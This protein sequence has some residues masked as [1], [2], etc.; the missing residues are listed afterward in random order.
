MMFK[1]MKSIIVFS[2]MVLMSFVFYS[3]GLDNAETSDDYLI[4]RSSFDEGTEGWVAE[5][6]D[7]PEGLEDSMKLSS[8]HSPLY[9]SEYVGNVSALKQS[10]YATNSDLFMFVKQEVSGLRPNSRYAIQIEVELSSQL[11]EEYAGDIDNPDFGSFLKVGAFKEEPVTILEEDIDNPEQ[12][13]VRTDFDKGEND[14]GGSDMLMIGRL[15][16]TPFG[17]TPIMLN[18]ANEDVLLNTVTDSEGKLWIAVGVDT[19]IPVFQEISYTFI[20]VQFLYQES[21]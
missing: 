7:Y 17:E 16:Y 11:L 18:G 1:A 14:K 4:E 5:F 9:V 20:F 6:A 3:C 12:K 13:I 8:T 21:L 15:E 19:N 2:I 10:G